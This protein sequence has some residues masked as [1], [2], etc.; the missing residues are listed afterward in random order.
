MNKAKKQ[1][2]LQAIRGV[3]T[4]VDKRFMDRGE[5]GRGMYATQ[6]EVEALRLLAAKLVIVFG[7]LPGVPF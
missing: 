4:E 2:F 5:N 1:V 7:P 3:Q 6:E